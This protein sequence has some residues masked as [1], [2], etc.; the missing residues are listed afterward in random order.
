MNMEMRTEEIWSV[1]KRKKYRRKERSESKTRKKRRD[2]VSLARIR[3]LGLCTG[4]RWVCMFFY[5]CGT[6]SSSCADA[7]PAVTGLTWI[8]Q[9]RL[10]PCDAAKRSLALIS[11]ST[12]FICNHT[13][14]CQHSRD[15][16]DLPSAQLPTLS[17]SCLPFSRCRGS[18]L[19]T[20]DKPK[21]FPLPELIYMQLPG[22]NKGR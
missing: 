12:E 2:S 16:E 10:K 3:W 5:A 18:I 8:T 19:C 17:S 22:N 4:F 9:K 11:D 1:G 20:L 15:P 14:T 13:A 21:W 7:E 6:K